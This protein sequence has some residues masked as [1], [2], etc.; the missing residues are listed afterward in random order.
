M[1]SAFSAT[2]I[3]LLLKAEKND[4]E[5]IKITDYIVYYHIANDKTTYYVCKKYSCM[6][7]ANEFSI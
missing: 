2:R 5:L 6:A 3:L 4:E 7:P 1:Y